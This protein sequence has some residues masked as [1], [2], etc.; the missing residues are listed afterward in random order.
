MAPPRHNPR[1]IYWR[2]ISHKVIGRSYKTTKNPEPA[3]LENPHQ[4]VI[5]KIYNMIR[6]QQIKPTHIVIQ[7]NPQGSVVRLCP[8]L[9]SPWRLQLTAVP[10]TYYVL[11]SSSN[12]SDTGHMHQHL[13]GHKLVVVWDI[14][15][16]II[17]ATARKIFRD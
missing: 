3:F 16:S 17:N 10:N 5:Q 8:T 2:R 12:L 7:V 9:Y 4:A 14:P 13:E 6:G 11:P 15:I 1:Q